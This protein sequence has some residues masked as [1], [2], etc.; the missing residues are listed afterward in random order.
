MTETAQPAAAATQPGNAL[1][2][3]KRDVVDVVATRVNEMIG[4]GRLQIPERYAVGNAIAAWWLK[5]QDC[6]D[7]DNRPALSVCTRDSIANATL[8]MV[9]LG[10]APQKN[11]CY[12][13][14]YGRSLVCQRS[15]FGEE[16]IVLRIYRA[17]GYPNARVVAQPIYKGDEFVYEMRE[18]SPV[19]VKHEQ[20]LENVVAD[21]EAILGGYCIVYSGGDLPP[22]TVIRTMA[23]VKKAW[24]KSKTWKPGKAGTFHEDTPDHAVR[25]TL[26]RRACTEIINSSDDSDLAAAVRQADEAA[27]EIA[28]EAEV[29]EHANAG[30]ILEI[31]A[32][33]LPEPEPSPEDGALSDEEKAEIEAAEAGEA[34]EPSP[35]R[36]QKMV[37]RYAL[38]PAKAKRIAANLL[39]IDDLR[40]MGATE[41]E[42]VLLDEEAF[43]AAYRKAG[44]KVGGLPDAPAPKSTASAGGGW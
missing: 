20:R 7:K 1:A 36:F 38:D 43:L 28:M 10:L 32:G 33:T 6:K 44:G 5:L 25:R 8:Q 40:R 23:Q 16:A 22:H 18:G 35:V 34:E 37:E 39:D 21:T 15:Y 27:A 3:I 26:I 41:Y 29:E 42:T 19:V 2:L 31:T 11:Q 17:M 9:V 30:P 13:V 12:P 24:E 4:A 14:V